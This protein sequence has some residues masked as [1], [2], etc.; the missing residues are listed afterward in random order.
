MHQL[1]FHPPSLLFS[2]SLLSSIRYGIVVGRVDT[3]IVVSHPEPATRTQARARNEMGQA[4]ANPPRAGDC[5][6][7]IHPT[8][9]TPY[10]EQLAPT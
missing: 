1:R 4:D 3:S 8:A 2:R 10:H 9:V 5:H 7:M 6:L